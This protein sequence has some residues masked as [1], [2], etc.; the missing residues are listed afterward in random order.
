MVHNMSDR[1]EDIKT[2]SPVSQYVYCGRIVGIELLSS[3][4][5]ED[6]EIFLKHYKH[7]YFPPSGFIKVT[8]NVLEQPMCTLEHPWNT[9][10]IYIHIHMVII[11]PCSKLVFTSRCFR[12]TRDFS[13]LCLVPM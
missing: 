5:R 11:R 2:D 6:R 9:L 10:C 12:I 8:H 3:L 13:S 4:Q 1:P 7:E